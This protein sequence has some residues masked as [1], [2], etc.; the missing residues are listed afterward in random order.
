MFVDLDSYVAPFTGA[1]IETFA[2]F[3]QAPFYD[4]AP[5]TGAWIETR[6]GRSPSDMDMVAPFTGAGSKTLSAM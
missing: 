1:W 5:F 2:P 3:D 6:Q 4:V